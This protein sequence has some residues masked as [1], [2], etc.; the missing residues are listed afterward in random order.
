MIMNKFVI[1][2][3]TEEVKEGLSFHSHGLAFT[4][5]FD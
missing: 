3:F 1:V 2:S 4:F 5:D